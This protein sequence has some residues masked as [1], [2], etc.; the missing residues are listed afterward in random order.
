MMTILIIQETTHRIADIAAT[1]GMWANVVVLG[2]VQ[3]HDHSLTDLVFVSPAARESELSYLLSN[4][5][6]NTLI[7]VGN[8]AGIVVGEFV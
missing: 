7:A 8:G 1:R 4:C 2:V 6:N 5:E 3:H